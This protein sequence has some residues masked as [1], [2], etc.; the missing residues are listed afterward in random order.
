MRATCRI[1]GAAGE[2]TVPVEDFC[3]APGVNVLKPGELLISLNIPR[4]EPHSAARYLRF[5]PRNEMDIAVAGAGVAVTITD[6]TITSARVSLASVAP[7]PLYVKAAEEAIIGK[8]ATEE[9]IATAA[10][11]AKQAAQ[12][13][14]DMRGTAGY[15][16][17]LC[18]V[19]TRRALSSAIAKAKES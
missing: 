14:T 10:A 12:P 9:T 18:A 15:R 8:P 13:I 16:R 2:R 19:L 17:H 3:T 11:I 1:A 6:G 4:P 5:I 7:T